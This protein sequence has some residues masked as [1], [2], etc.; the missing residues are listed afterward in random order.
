MGVQSEKRKVHRVQIV[1]S[2]EQREGL[3]GNGIE[4]ERV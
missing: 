1:Y 2:T 3:R 4:K